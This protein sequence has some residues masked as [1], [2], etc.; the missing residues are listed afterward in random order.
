MGKAVKKI[1]TVAAIGAAAFYGGQALA[2][3]LSGGTTL[4]GAYTTGLG[5]VGGAIHT[6]AGVA[7][8]AGVGTGLFG[9]TALQRAGIGLQAVSYLKQRKAISAQASALK[10]QAEENK[11]INEM[12]R[13]YREA[14][15]RRQR[16][17]VM[18]QTRGRI[19]MMEAG[20]A[21]GG[22]SI[23]GGTSALAGA[24]GAIQT[25]ATANLENINLASGASTAISEGS[26]RAADFGTKANIAYGQQQ[27]WSNLASL[28]GNL[29]KNSAKYSDAGNALFSIFKT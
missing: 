2:G 7:T 12:Q 3:Y 25:S 22:L 11:R 23:G 26:Q 29:M 10:Q 9:A 4:G 21:R 6:G 15:E 18:E 16:Y 24:T 27:G 28:G 8:S 14:M 5:T 17:N 20:A 13:R 19:G 1:A